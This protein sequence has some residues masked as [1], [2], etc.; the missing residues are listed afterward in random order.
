VIGV[1]RRTRRTITGWPDPRSQLILWPRCCKV[2]GLADQPREWFLAPLLAIDEAVAGI[3]DGTL[4]NY[5]YEPKLASFRQ[6]ESL[7]GS[8][9]PP[10]RRGRAAQCS[11][12]VS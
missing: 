1:R 6:R 12:E 11:S 3:K 2:A 9:K 4:V 8:Y 5:V 10:V 7:T